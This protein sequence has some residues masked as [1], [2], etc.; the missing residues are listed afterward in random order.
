MIGLDDPI[1]ESLVGGYRV[2]Y[3]PVERLRELEDGSEDPAGVWDEFWEELHH[4]GDVD[5][6]SYAVVPQLARICTER[7]LLD[8]NIFALIAII[9]EC[10]IFGKNPKL[11][12][13]LEVDYHQAIKTMAEYGASRF[14]REWPAEMTQS[15]L[16]VAAFAK[17]APQTGR[18][19]VNF[20][21]DEMG[22]VFQKAFE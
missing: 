21:E 12:T 11:P 18:L 22:E 9:E 4:Q 1:W 19:L 16:A 15:F 6:A 20:S 13:W 17:G 14:T 7:D 5:T 8:W 3:N 10:R 2:Q